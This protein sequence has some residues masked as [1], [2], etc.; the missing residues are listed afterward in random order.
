MKKSRTALNCAAFA[1][2][3]KKNAPKQ[4]FE[5]FGAA[6]QTRTADLVIT[7]DVLYHLSY[8]SIGFAA[9]R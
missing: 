8:S 4:N 9:D 1:I 5:A 3:K 2:D 6:R 7:N